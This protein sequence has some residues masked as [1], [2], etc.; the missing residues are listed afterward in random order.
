MPG[1]QFKMIGKP[2]VVMGD[3]GD[4]IAL[5]LFESE[6][7]IG[8]AEMRRLGQIEPSEPNPAT[9]SAVPSVQPSPTMSSSKSRSLCQ[10]TD[11]I[12]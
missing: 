11:L 3:K 6:V 1:Q 4:Q 7:S 12:A 9:S 2:N 8:V 5:R 10:S